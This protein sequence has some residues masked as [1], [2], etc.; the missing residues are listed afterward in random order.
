MKKRFKKKI[1]LYIHYFF[2]NLLKL[3]KIINYIY[4][5][6]LQ[7]IGQVLY[8]LVGFI[9]ALILILEFGFYYPDEW[10]STVAQIGN[11]IILFFLFYEI[12]SFIFTSSNFWDYLR[13]HIVEFIII[14]LVLLQD[15]FKD[16]II[17]LLDPEKAGLL[18]LSISQVFFLFSNISHLIRNTKFYDI[19]KISP[20]LLFVGSFAVIIII[21]ALV[22]HFP[23]ATNQSIPT[24]DIL[25]TAVSATCVTGLSTLNIASAFTFTGQV[26][27]ILLM[28]AGGLGIMTLASFFG[29]FLTGKTSVNDKLLMKDLLSE[30]SLG[31]VKYLLLRI[32]IFSFVIEGVGTIFM[33]FSLPESIAIHW[34]DKLFIAIFHSV[35]SFCNAGFSLLPNGFANQEILNSKIFLSTSMVLIT[36]GGIGFPVLSQTYKK[37]LNP[38]N[39]R[40]RYSVSA[41]IVLIT[42][43]ILFVLCAVFFFVLEKNLSLKD[44]SLYDKIFHSL[45][46]SV[47]LRTAG[48]NTIDMTLLGESMVFF[49]LFFMWVGASPTSTGGGIKTTTFS[50][51]LLNIWFNIRGKKNVEFSK[52]T[53]SRSSI[54]RASATILLS[55]FVIFISLFLLTF[56]EKSNFLDLAFEI[57]SA[58]GTVGLSRG[59]TEK[60][61]FFGK[62]VVMIVM[63][64]GRIGVFNL[65]LAMIQDIEPANYQYPEEEV[66]VS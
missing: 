23:K 52:R 32:A 2:H 15:L 65:I 43:L 10:S 66:V 60:L 25:F 18:F 50:I 5:E 61:S 48:F 38:N 49:S 58:Y 36:F 3:K 57:V 19:K 54:S 53:I 4:V 42:S 27:L 30:Q 1:L 9:S 11:A 62:I 12:A 44:L 34:M 55:F 29:I 37:I 20:S 21:G 26:I 22:L 40:I 35:S 56:S 45:F 33:Y 41:K 63:F 39:P 51:A 46:Y 8:V 13:T 28:Q 24:I 6:Y 59:I 17:A 7:N 14:L 47:T 31:E 64:I 16:S